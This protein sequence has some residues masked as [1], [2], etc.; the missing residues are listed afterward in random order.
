MTLKLDNLDMTIVQSAGWMK[1]TKISQYLGYLEYFVDPD[2]GTGL[3][4]IFNTKDL[5]LSGGKLNY[6]VDF[7]RT[8]STLINRAAVT[9]KTDNM[10]LGILGVYDS[11]TTVMND[12]T[13]AGNFNG[14][15]YGDYT[16][17]GF[18]VKGQFAANANTDGSTI[19]KPYIGILGLAYAPDKMLSVSLDSVYNGNSGWSTYD[20]NLVTEDLKASYSL[21]DSLSLNAENVAKLTNDKFKPTADQVTVGGTY[22]TVV[23]ITPT[24]VFNLPVVSGD[25]FN[26][27]HIHL[28]VS[29]DAFNVDARWTPNA[30]FTVN[31]IIAL[32]TYHL[33][34]TTSV[35]LG[36]GY[37]G[38]K[39]DTTPNFGFAVNYS[40]ITPFEAIKSPMFFASFDYNLTN[41]YE[42]TDDDVTWQSVST[43]D[44]DGT[45]FSSINVAVGATLRAG[46]KFSF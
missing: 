22:K 33:D 38:D 29:K 26:F 16:V 15:V 43:T 6:Y 28:N 9:Y 2:A 24:A 34:T 13:K 8:G 5:G 27:D 40:M 11:K 46:L 14:S 21:S 25:K 32:S 36:L 30:D 1:A 37:L 7:D 35:G 23:D 19:E 12:F 41:E 3:T 4:E 31:K 20:Q 44:A 39:V 45:D 18:T 17:S 42:A 10:N